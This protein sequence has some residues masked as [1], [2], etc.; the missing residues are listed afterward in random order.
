MIV[1]FPLI[2][3]EALVIIIAVNFCSFMNSSNFLVSALCKI[4]IKTKS[5]LCWNLYIKLLHLVFFFPLVI[6]HFPETRLASVL[7]VLKMPRGLQL[8]IYSLGGT[9]IAWFCSTVAGEHYN[10]LSKPCLENRLV[11]YMSSKLRLWE[12]ELWWLWWSWHF[13]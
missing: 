1:F 11:L 2:E 3:I 12:L 7:H 8:V 9:T 4:A 5:S 10:T 13:L 6:P